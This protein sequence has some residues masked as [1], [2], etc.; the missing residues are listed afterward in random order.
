MKP[1]VCHSVSHSVPF[2]HSSVL[3]NVHCNKLLVCFKASRFCYTINTESLPGLFLDVLLLPISWRSCSF[4]SLGPAPSPAPAVH[5]WDRCWDGPTQSP[6]SEPELNLSWSGGQLFC[7]L[8][9][10]VR[11]SASPQPAH[12]IWKPARSQ[13]QLFSSHALGQ[14]PASQQGQL[15]Y[16]SQERCRNH[17]PNYCRQTE[18][19]GL[20]SSLAFMILGLAVLSAIGRV[21][22]GTSL[23]HPCQYKAGS[24]YFGQNTFYFYIHLT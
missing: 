3:A 11:S 14:H 19:Q 4:G 13:G 18:R 15:Y 16:L 24:N 10:S 17:S 1:V 5:K 6:G 7:T 9:T 20:I 23:S 22:V 12:P 2:V 8:T 21:G